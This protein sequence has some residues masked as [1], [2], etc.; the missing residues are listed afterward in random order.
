M[1]SR[2]W[3]WPEELST[4]RRLSLGIQHYEE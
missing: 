3:K 2:V 1:V 4:D